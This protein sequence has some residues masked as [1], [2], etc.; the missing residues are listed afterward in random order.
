MRKLPALLA[1]LV[2]C[3][4]LCIAVTRPAAAQLGIS[5]AF[6]ASRLD[7]PVTNVSSPSMLYG[8]TVSVYYQ[9]G[10][11]LSLGGDIRGTFLGRNGITFNA[12]TAGPR[13]ALKLHALPIQV[14]AEALGGFNSYTSSTNAGSTIQ[15]EYQLLVG[16]DAT[17]LPRIDWRVLEYAYTGSSANLSANSLSTGIVLRLPF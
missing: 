9:R 8:S 16:G 15:A 13:V 3:L 7:H 11:L 5:G 17:I 1:T 12:G 10:L 6:T 14:Y 4:A 2:L